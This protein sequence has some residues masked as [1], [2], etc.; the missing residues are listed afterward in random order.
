MNNAMKIHRLILFIIIITASILYSQKKYSLS[1]E[2]CIRLAKENSPSSK[3]AALQLQ[4]MKFDHQSFYSGLLPQIGLRLSSPQF[5]RAINSFVLDDGTTSYLTQKEAFS[6]LNLQI[7][8]LIPFTGGQLFLSSG[9][10]RIDLF[11]DTKSH[12]WR[13]TPFRLELRQPLFSYNPIKWEWKITDIKYRKSISEWYEKME[14]ISYEAT[15]KFFELYLAKSNLEIAEANFTVND[16]IYFISQGRYNVGKIAEN[17]LL[18]SEFELLAAETNV[19]RAKLELERTKE[20]IRIFLG[21]PDDVDLE[22]ESVQK[23]S[24][25][26]INSN[27][28]MENAKKYRSDLL[29]FK[30]RRLEAKEAVEI[31]E[32][33]SGLAANLIASIGYNQSAEDFSQLYIDLLDQQYFNLT[34][35]LPLFTWG[36]GA[37]QIEAATARFDEVETEV[38]L[39]EKEFENNVFFQAKEVEQL[40]EQLLLSAKADT[41]A[42]RRFEVAK[43]RYLIGKID[44]T[45]LFLAQREK[46]Q[47]KRNYINTQRN[48]WLALYRLRQLTLY[49]FQNET[50]IIN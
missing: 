10:E 13:T 46:D 44:I 35:N 7:S 42:G 11:G 19:S 25:F 45:N 24:A 8:Q 23:I 41:I 14:G 49:D 37:A 12:I 9:L 22:V 1:L 43:N 26:P 16:T 32:S 18:Q 20:D 47:A 33:N 6:S 3:I 48:F 2:N 34:F 15:S 40:M 36:K 38:V 30:Q 21:L 28:A 31:A 39:D 50:P 4:A 17:E 27:I 29:T 5:N